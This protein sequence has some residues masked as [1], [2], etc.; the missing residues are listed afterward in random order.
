MNDSSYAFLPGGV[1]TLILA[2]LVFGRRNKESEV[3]V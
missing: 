1:I 2:A 3:E